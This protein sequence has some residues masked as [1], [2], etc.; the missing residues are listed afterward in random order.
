M[1]VADTQ[2]GG[3]ILADSMHTIQ[4][5]THGQEARAAARAW[6]ARFGD[7]AA[8]AGPGQL[9]EFVLLLAAAGHQEEMARGIAAER[10]ALTAVL[11]NADEHVWADHANGG[12]SS[13]CHHDHRRSPPRG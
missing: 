8:E 6:L 5:V 2:L 13:R 11:I 10:L 12:G 7:A 4:D 3:A 1:A 9:L